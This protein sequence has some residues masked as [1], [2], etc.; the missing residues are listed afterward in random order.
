MLSSSFSEEDGHLTFQTKWMRQRLLAIDEEGRAYSGGL[1]TD[2]TYKLF[3]NGY[4]CSTS[5]YDHDLCRWIPILFTWLNGLHDEHYAAHFRSLMRC[6][7]DAPMTPT[8][9]NS[10]VRQ[11]V[12]FSKA[13]KK[14]FIAAYMDVFEEHDPRKASFR[15]HGCH[16]HYRASITRLKRNHAVIPLGQDVRSI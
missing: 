1:L 14:G 2:V 15:L 13:Q 3:K 6:L 16:E 5:M 11:V 10:L 9:R 12:G 7:K 4:L 8:Q